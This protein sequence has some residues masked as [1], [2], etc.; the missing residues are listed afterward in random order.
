MMHFQADTLYLAVHLLNRC[1]R[2]MK[3]TTANLQLLGM[4]CLFVA[5]KKE[6]SLL[7]EVELNCTHPAAKLQNYFFLIMSNR[8]D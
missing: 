6:E 7:P 3:V 4:V 5:G 2:Q 8:G 1:L